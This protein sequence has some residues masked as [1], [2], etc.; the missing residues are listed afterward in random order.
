MSAYRSYCQ[1]Q[2]LECGRRARLA[3]SPEVADYHRTLE[4]GWLKLAEK[5]RARARLRDTTGRLA[6][7]AVQAV[8]TTRAIWRDILALGHNRQAA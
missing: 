7:E 8:T 3:C 1:R 5:E 2:A 4:L 6:A